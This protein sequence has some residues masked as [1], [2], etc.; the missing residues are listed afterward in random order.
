M[1]TRRDIQGLRA[2]AVTLVIVF[3]L[4]PAVLPGGFVGVDVFF[5]I[6]GYLISRHLLR[7]L[8]D[9]GTVSVSRFWARR[10]RR[11]LPAAS[12]TLLACVLV[13]LVVLPHAYWR[14]NLAGIVASAF[15]V[16]NWQLVASATDYMG[17]GGRVTVVQHFWS[18]AVEEQFYVL[19]PLFLVLLAAITPLATR[20]RASAVLVAAILVASFAYSVYESQHGKALA[21]FS[22]FTRAWE[23]AAGALIVFLPPL[24]AERTRLRLL[25]AWA[26]L[27]AILVGAV[28]ISAEHPFPGYIAVIPIL[29]TMYVIYAATDDS[30]STLARGFALR[31][32]Q[33]LGDASYSAYLWHWPLVVAAPYLV[34]DSLTAG[35]SVLALTLLLAG[36]SKRFVEDPFLQGDRWASRQPRFWYGFAA[37]GMAIV[38]AITLPLW[39]RS[40]LDARPVELAQYFADP[41]AAIASALALDQW[42][43]AN[44]QRGDSAQA[45]EWKQDGCIDIVDDDRV[46]RCTYGP[47][48]AEKRMAVIGDSFATHF[49]PAL[50]SGFPGWRVQVLTLGQCPLARVDVHQLGRL[51]TFEGCSAHRDLVLERLAADPPDLIVA[52]DS[53]L[54][55]LV[56]L[57]SG[58]T[59]E[60]AYAE[61]EYGYRRAYAELA[62]LPSP[63]LILE[64]PP[65]ANCTAEADLS[66]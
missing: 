1:T 64:S 52:A 46:K 57:M 33:W 22:T 17:G 53:T 60:A 58:H 21:Y 4:W 38:V 45:P 62:R 13:L 55:A 40:A 49:L 18:L 59:G 11:L 29:G 61:L 50:R 32:V 51:D 12:V 23:L 15:Y 26:G 28:V 8:H 48:D 34:A 16:Q 39:Q 56:R 14:E 36:S 7:E 6:S 30:R 19:W 5:V 43:T 31:P 24:Q 20:W 41:S 65:R 27:G 9:T 2:L 37:A 35:A 25:L 66:P 54:N 47:T 63:V 10:V 44:E 42:P 3:H